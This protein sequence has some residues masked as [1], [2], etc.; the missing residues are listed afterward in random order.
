MIVVVCQI[1]IAAQFGQRVRWAGRRREKIQAMNR[2]IQRQHRVGV[3]LGGAG[4][5][6]RVSVC[7]AAGKQKKGDDCDAKSGISLQ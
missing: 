6:R 3:G 4:K 5:Q 2:R 7:G 1:E